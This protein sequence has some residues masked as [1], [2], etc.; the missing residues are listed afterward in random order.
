MPLQGD[1]AAKTKAKNK[2]KSNNIMSENHPAIII[3]TLSDAA[4]LQ[5]QPKGYNQALQPLC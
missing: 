1:K 2:T 5:Q 4:F 3:R